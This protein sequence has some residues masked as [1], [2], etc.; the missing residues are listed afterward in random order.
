MQDGAIRYRT[1]RPDLSH[2][3]IDK[4]SWNNSVYGDIKEDTPNNTPE[5]KGNTVDTITY[6]NANLLHDMIS[7]KF[8]T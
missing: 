1:A 3:P 6:V 2:L 4:Y 8:V 7:G 5:A